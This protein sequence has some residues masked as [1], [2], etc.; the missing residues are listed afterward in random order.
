M[1]DSRVGWDHRNGEKASSHWGDVR[2]LICEQSSPT[3]EQRLSLQLRYYRLV[4]P[5]VWKCTCCRAGLWLRRDTGGGVD[6]SVLLFVS[7]HFVCNLQSPHG[8][9]L[10]IYFSRIFLLNSEVTCLRVFSTSMLPHRGLLLPICCFLFPVLFWPPSLYSNLLPLLLPFT[11]PLHPSNV[12]GR[13]ISTG[14]W[15]L[16]APPSLWSLPAIVLGPT[17]TRLLHSINST[18]NG[19]IANI[20]CSALE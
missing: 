18:H 1:E 14:S 5:S 20:H 6:S 4:G 11:P 16:A 3:R 13:T 17:A 10:H 19:L 2:S 9:C 12:G 7:C 8:I 15:W